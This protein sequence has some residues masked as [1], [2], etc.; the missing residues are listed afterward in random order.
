MSSAALLL[1]FAALKLA[2][3]LA[4][5]E[6]Y[7][8]FRDELYYLACADH[9]DLGYVDHPPLSIFIL[10]VVRAAFGDSILALRLAAAAAGM[11]SV[12]LTGLLAGALGGGRMAQAL[13]MTAVL[14]A[15]VMLGVNSFYS[16]N[17]LE[18]LL[19]TGAALV[20]AR[21]LD[22]GESRGW[23]LL[24]LLVG[25]GLLNK[26]SMLWFAGGLALGILA[27][28]QR[29]VLGTR[30]PWVAA[31]IAAVMVAPHLLWQLD[32]GWPTLEFMRNA[33]ARKMVAV[34]PLE[35][36]GNQVIVMNPLTIPL[37]V[38]GLVFFFWMDAGRR[39]RPLGWVFVA[40]FALLAF[41]GTSRA[42]YLAP[43]Y[44][45]LL[46]GGGFALERA[47]SRP[48][49]G[50][51]GPVLLGAML[52]AGAATAPLAL[53]LLGP[54][55]YAGYA[56]ALGVVPPVEERRDPA[57]LPQHL[58]DRHGWTEIADTVASVYRSLPSRDR[59]IAGVF[60]GNYGEAAAIDHFGPRRGLPRA[61]SGHNSYW[62]WGPNGYS[63]EVMI[64]LGIRRQTLE[65]LFGR[66]DEV[67]RVGC[68]F[69]MPFENDNPV[70]VCRE[71]KQPLREMWGRAKR[72]F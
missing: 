28:G 20:V 48:R 61:I 46:A 41:A 31:A 53:P 8:Y 10:W 71:P 18:I 55:R 21:L 17:S 58:A 64:V 54:E 1:L 68:R 2:A 27:T 57:V 38:A 32:H 52:L 63:G 47:G 36:L 33:S 49:W 56:A 62:L 70:Y 9:L 66:V 37:W 72:Y 5:G 7:G 25:L 69:C 11:L 3:H 29:R 4:C 19:W 42:N 34:S 22:A 15:P 40:T 50:W 12:V 23:L 35:F 24:G 26:I 65:E 44:P 45:A 51:L 59:E 43:A 13:A 6:G 67:A 30:W 14:I 39:F 16:M 60:A